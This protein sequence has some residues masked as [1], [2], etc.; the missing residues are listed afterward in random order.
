M[1]TV[2]CFI[3]LWWLTTMLHIHMANN[4]PSVAGA[5][6][7]KV[8]FLHFPT[9]CY[10]QQSTETNPPVSISCQF[11][12]SLVSGL[13]AVI[14]HC[15]HPTVESTWSHIQLN[16]VRHYCVSLFWYFVTFSE[17]VNTSLVTQI[18]LLISWVRGWSCSGRGESWC[19]LCAGLLEI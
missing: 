10:I 9:G 12:G 15:C 2:H 7:V 4:Y 17:K 5:R 16:H 18:M 3:T 14:D 13:I 1:N 6:K 19:G 11:A 8:L